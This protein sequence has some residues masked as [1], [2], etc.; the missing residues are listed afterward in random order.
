MAQKA[1]LRGRSW[2]RG[3]VGIP[4]RPKMV[5]SKWDASSSEISRQWDVALTGAGGGLPAGQTSEGSW[6][7]ILRLLKSSSRDRMSS[8]TARFIKNTSYWAQHKRNW[9]K[10][11]GLQT[12]EVKRDDLMGS[13]GLEIHRNILGRRCSCAAE[14]PLASCC[15]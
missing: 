7:Q 10:F 3:N 11:S 4:L 12:W 2:P 15:K 5:R 6:W 14:A 13:S 1:H 9:V 8:W